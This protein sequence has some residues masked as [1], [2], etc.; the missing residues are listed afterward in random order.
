VLQASASTGGGF[1]F[2]FPIKVSLFPSD[3]QKEVVFSS[4][5]AEEISKNEE[6]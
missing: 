4:L 5:Q 6:N 1:F 3:R 2:L